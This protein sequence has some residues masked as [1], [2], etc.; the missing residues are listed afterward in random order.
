MGGE[1]NRFLLGL[2]C[3][4][5]GC[6]RFSC[7]SIC[8]DVERGISVYMLPRCI[9]KRRCRSLQSKTAH[10]LSYRT[11]TKSL[12]ENRKRKELLLHAH[13]RKFRSLT[14]GERNVADIKETVTLSAEVE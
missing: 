1:V 8:S 2:P 13:P 7:S 4:F 14:R 12:P 10:N 6:G 3:G 5:F 11:F 9:L